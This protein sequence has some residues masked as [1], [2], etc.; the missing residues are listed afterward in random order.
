MHGE[1]MATKTISID[2]KAYE[3]L[4]TAR[5]SSKES[6]SKVIHRAAWDTKRKTCGDFLAGLEGIPV[7]SEEVLAR[8]EEAQAWDCENPP[9]SRSLLEQGS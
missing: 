3:I 8:L 5:E 6:F 4:R 1:C 9:P 2:L 7:T